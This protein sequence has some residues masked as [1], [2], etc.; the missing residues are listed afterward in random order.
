M[1]SMLNVID[2]SCVSLGLEY[3]RRYQTKVICGNHISP[4]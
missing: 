1:G 4:L 3:I 2:I